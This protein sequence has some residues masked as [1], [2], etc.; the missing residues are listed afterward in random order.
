[1]LVGNDK[2]MLESNTSKP[3][4]GGTLFQCQQVEWVQ[5]AYQLM[6]LSQVDQCQ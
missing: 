3:T 1:M 4:A 6:T 5:I 2:F